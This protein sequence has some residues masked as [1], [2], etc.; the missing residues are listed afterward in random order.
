MAEIAQRSVGAGL[1]RV[2]GHAKVTG[3]ARYAAEYPLPG[4]VHGC[5]VGAGV[6]R[7]T[8]RPI[9]SAPV[10]AMPGVLAVIDHRN[11]PALASTGDADTQ[12][13]QRDHV[14][15]R[16][17]AVALVVAATLEQARAG[18]EALDVRFEQQPHDTAF[19]EHHPRLFAPADVNTFDTDTEL[20]TVETAIAAA[21]FVVEE[22]F[23]T[24]AQNNA[25]MEP[26][27]ATVH[28]VDGRL[29]AFDSNQ[30]AT[31]VHQ[32]LC[33]L[34]GLA[35]D[36]VQVR[37][38]HVGGGFGSKGAI[39]LPVIAAAMASRMLDR[40]VRVVLTRAQLFSL[41]GYRTPTRQRVRL[42]ADATGRLLAVEHLTFSQT[43]RLVEFAEPTAVFARG[44]YATA[45]LRTRHRLVTLDVPTPRWMRAPGEAPGSF[46]LES[47]MDEL[48]FAAG[49][50]PIVLRHLNEP[51]VEPATGR[52]FADRNLLRCLDEGAELFGWAGRDGRPGRRTDGRWLVGTGVAAASY[53]ARAVGST[54]RVTADAGG[55]FTVRITASDI[56]TGARTALT[57]VACDE[58]GVPPER[59]TVLLGDSD[60][61][62]AMIAG[63]SMGTASWSF[64]I[65]TACRQ[66]RA[67]LAGAPK[68]PVE[69]TV[70]TS[71]APA[72]QPDLVR[73]AYGAQFAEV[74]VDSVTGEIRVPRLLGM[75]AVGRVINAKTARSQLVGGLIWGLSM[76]LLEE[77]VL[78]EVHGDYANHDLAGYHFAAHADVASVRA[79]WIDE[80]PDTGELDARAVKG[81]GEIGIVGTAAAVAN[82]VWHATGQ[83]HRDLP[84]RP[85][86]VM[87]FFE[88]GVPR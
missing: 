63:G 30:G 44:M 74:R 18:A 64:A 9:D 29:V 43:S 59:V 51:P 35:P 62:P 88:Q 4:L 47:A 82:A 54:A 7:G 67:L 78:D 45:N 87:S 33:T 15:H 61:G 21:A 75:Y 60:F 34:F 26:H 14:H 16:G 79:H 73:N 66:L 38:E 72:T 5:V 77:S 25:P 56:G 85:D 68:L 2:E 53:P 3:R 69:V 24:P 31:A 22:W 27:A 13:L 8:I 36:Q 86:R 76:A 42:G 46:G 71:A 10:L 48:A 40:P 81:L 52:R 23:S 50:D 28:W 32:A 19:S 65:V 80:H 39:S 70:D 17:Q 83:R 41:V 6:A 84:I 11:A 37:S 12:V 57:Q 1:S 58:L 20:G 49:L 55:D